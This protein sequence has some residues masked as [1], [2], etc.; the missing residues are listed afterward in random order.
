MSKHRDVQ[1]L[2]A[3]GDALVREAIGEMLR[4]AG[5]LVVAEASDGL[6]A[7]EETYS[8]L[9]DVVL[10][11]VDMPEMGGLEAAEII[12]DMCPTPIVMLAARDSLELLDKANG[13]TYVVKSPTA[14]ELE[15]AMASAR[16][17]FE[18]GLQRKVV[19]LRKA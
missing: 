5:Y 18:R 15:E 12:D 11:D 16:A 9:P 10:M 17:R 4:D 1:A 13:L 19:C 6:D 3:S 2:I 14:R 8:L 7:V